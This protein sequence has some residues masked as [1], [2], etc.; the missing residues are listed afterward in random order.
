MAGS[1]LTAP[2]HRHMTAPSRRLTRAAP[3]IAVIR[4]PPF[5]AC[6]SGLGPGELLFSPIGPLPTNPSFARLGL[7]ASVDAFEDAME[8]TVG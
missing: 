6:T 1:H 7:T 5:T 3:G 2:R 8:A 4:A